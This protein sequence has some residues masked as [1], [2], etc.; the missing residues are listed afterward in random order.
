MADFLEGFMC[1]DC[2]DS[3]SH[4]VRSVTKTHQRE[5]SR[6]TFFFPFSR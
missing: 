3:L 4:R 6:K 5:K 1:K 2:E